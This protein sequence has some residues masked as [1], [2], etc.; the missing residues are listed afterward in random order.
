RFY[1]IICSQIK[2]VRERNILVENG[3]MYLFDAMSSNGLLRFWRCRY[4]TECK[5]RVHTSIN[6]FD[7]IK[8]INEHTHYAEP[9]NIE[10][11]GA[12]CRIKKRAA[13]TMEPTSTVINECVIDLSQ[14][15]KR[16]IQS[17]QTLKKTVRRQRKIIQAIPDAPKDLISLQIPES[18]KIFS[19]SKDIEEQF[20]L[21][22]S[23]PGNDR[24]IIFRRQKNLDVLFRSKTW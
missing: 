23:S 3:F 11:N 16:I 15:A 24:I 1:N 4:K 20:L 13:E 6:D 14:A 9:A 7:I 2:S 22:D 10:T 12:V 18:Y 17:S 8:R 21:A 19:P 5:A